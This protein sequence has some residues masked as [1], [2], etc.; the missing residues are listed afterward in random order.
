MQVAFGYGHASLSKMPPIIIKP[1]RGFS[2][3]RNLGKIL[4]VVT[5]CIMTLVFCYAMAKLCMLWHYVL[6]I[7]VLYGLYAQTNLASACCM[8]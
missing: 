6:S 5:P 8:W 2:N 7:Y 1:T 4:H 3:D